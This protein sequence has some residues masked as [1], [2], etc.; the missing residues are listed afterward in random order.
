[1]SLHKHCQAMGVVCNTPFSQHKNFLNKSEFSHTIG[2][3]I[4]QNISNMNTL[5]FIPS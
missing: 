4:S 2:R 3:H 5:Q 1:M